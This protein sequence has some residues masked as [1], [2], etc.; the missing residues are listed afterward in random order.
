MR[1]G[2]TRAQKASIEQQETISAARETYA[3]M[4]KDMPA[5]DITPELYLYAAL[6]EFLMY[7]EMKA[8]VA[9]MRRKQPENEDIKALEAWVTTRASH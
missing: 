8:V 9:D 5:D 6:Y 2:L 3:Q 1:G 4:Q 7:D